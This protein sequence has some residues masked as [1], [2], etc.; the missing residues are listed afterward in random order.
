MGLSD[1]RLPLLPARC[2]ESC[3][4][5]PGASKKGRTDEANSLVR[6]FDE[7]CHGFPSFRFCSHRSYRPSDSTG[8]HVPDSS[9]N[10]TASPQL[11]Q[12]A[13]KLQAH[14]SASH[15]VSRV[16][17]FWQFR[18]LPESI[19]QGPSPQAH[20]MTEAFKCLTV[21]T[22]L[23][24]SMRNP[25]LPKLHNFIVRNYGWGL[26]SQREISWSSS[27]CLRVPLVVE[28]VPRQCFRIHN[29]GFCKTAL[30]PN[31]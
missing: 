11:F 26:G 17:T 2:L 1:S 7:P 10:H 12:G 3:L 30:G 16:R 28:I 23:S 14:A 24:R 29:G 19:S 20:R 25:K 6:R 4:F 5:T 13:S 21:L 18:I 31:H 15:Q 22:S 9:L 27:G 8:R